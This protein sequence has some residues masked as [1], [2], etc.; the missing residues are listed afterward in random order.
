[1]IGFGKKIAAIF[2][3]VGCLLGSMTLVS[4]QTMPATPTGSPPVRTA[5]APGSAEANLRPC[6][7]GRGSCTLIDNPLVSRGT[8]L[9][10]Q[11]GGV[12][13]YVLLL[14]GSVTL[15]MIVWGGFQWLTAAGNAEKIEQGS[16]TMIWAVIGVFAVFISYV[17]L[18]NYL[19]YLTG[20][21]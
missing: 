9:Y 12:V 2:A 20:A 19:D 14:I 7:D 16:K 17:L 5:P 10:R 3:V 18:N 15:L 11:V 21:K 8:D 13:G 4:A 6:P 1:M